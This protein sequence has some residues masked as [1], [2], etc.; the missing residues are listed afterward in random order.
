ASIARRSERVTLVLLRESWAGNAFFGGAGFGCFEPGISSPT[1]ASAPT[2]PR[3]TPNQASRR[4]GRGD[5][6]ATPIPARVPA[7][8]RLAAG[9]LEGRRLVRSSSGISRQGGR[10]ILRELVQRCG[11]RGAFRL[12]QGPDEQL[13]FDAIRAESER[14]AL[15]KR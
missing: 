3:P 10:N 11:V 4:R 5:A 9:R 12:L 7:K 1:A 8:R 13:V 6:G 2:M 15:G 14:R